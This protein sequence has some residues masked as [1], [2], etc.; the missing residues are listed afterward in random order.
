MLNGFRSGIPK[1]MVSSKTIA[2]E[3]VKDEPGLIVYKQQQEYTPRLA[4]FSKRV[5]S[6]IS[7]SLDDQGKVKYHK[8]VSKPQRVSSL[9]QSLHRSK[10]LF[11][12]ACNAFLVLSTT[13]F[14]QLAGCPHLLFLPSPNST[15]RASTGY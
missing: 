13:Q 1:V 6:L 15:I 11:Q 10:A 4:H 3:V 7:L 9:F 12:R 14:P 5:D 2:T 8:D